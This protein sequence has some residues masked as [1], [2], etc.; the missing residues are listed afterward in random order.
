M[1]QRTS[2]TARPAAAKRQSL[3]SR[4]FLALLVV[5]FTVAL[6]D[7]IFRWL[8]IPIG[9]DLVASDD[10]VRSVGSAV[11]LVPFILLAGLAGFAADRYSKRSVMM[12]AKLAEIVVMVLGIIA[13]LSG[14]VVFLAVVLF[15]MGA[16]STF[17][18]PAKYGSIPEIVGPKLVSVANGWIGMTT[19]MAVIL[20]TVIGN[21]IYS[22]TTLTGGPAGIGPGQH[23][24]WINAAV[25]IGIATVG[26]LASFAVG[27]LPAGNPQSKAPRN[28]FAQTGRDLKLLYSHRGLFLAALGSAYFWSL[29]VLATLNID[30]LAVPELVGSTGQQYVGPMLAI[31]TLGIGLGSL[32][33]GIWSRGRIELGM[34]GIGALGIAL[35]AIMFIAVPTGTGQWWSVPYFVTCF[36]LFA[37]GAT[38]GLYDIPLLAFLQERSP[39]ESRGRILA[40]YNFLSFSGMLAFSGLFGLL[41]EVMGLPARGIFLLAGLATLPIACFIIYLVPV[42]TFRFVFDQFVRTVYGM[43]IVGREN[44]PQEGGAVVVSNHIS[45]LDGMIIMLAMPRHIRMVAVS[46][47]VSWGVVGR[48][49]RRAGVIPI[50]LRRKAMAHAMREAKQAVRDGKLVGLF[51]EGGISRT[52]QLI[53]FRPGFLHLVDDETPVVPVFIDGL[54]GSIFSF[55]RRR[56][57]WK[58]PRRLR[59]PLTV[60]IGQPIYG[61][62]TLHQV[63]RAVGELSVTAAQNRRGRFLVPPRQFLRQARAN[64]FRTKAADSLGMSVTGAKLLLGSFVLRRVLRRNHLASPQK[65]Q[66][67]GVL[68]PPSVGGLVV[69]AALAI[70]RRGAVNLNYTVSNDVLNHCLRSCCIRHVL[71]SRRF[72]ERFEFDLDAELVFIE[73]LP[74]RAGWL[75]KLTALLGTYL[76]PAWV[77]ERVLKLTRIKPDDLLTVVFT[78]GSTGRPKGV[79]LSQMNVGSNVEAFEQ[80]LDIRRNDVLCGILPFFHSFGYS[81]TLWAALQLL[82]KVVYHFNP[83][84][85]RQVGNL[86]RQHRATILVA[87]PTFLRSYVR[88]CE[89]EDF[90]HL[91]VVI[92]GAEKLPPDV[93]QAFEERFGVRPWEGYGTTET[94]P[95]VSSNIPASR[96]RDPWFDDARPGSVGRPMPYVIAK[97]A[98]VDTGED[99]GYDK[100]GMLW[101]KGPNVMQ[102][103]LGDPE[104]TAEVI[105]DGWYKTGDIAQIDR[106]NF[107]HIT[108][109]QSRFSKIAG[110]MV[111][112]LRIEEA[113]SQLLQLGDQDETT[114]AV[115]GV[116]DPKKGERIVVLYSALPT[117]PEE[118]CRRLGSESGL[119]TIW[120]PSPRSFYRVNQIPVL[121]S[122]KLDLKRLHDLAV[123]VAAQA[124]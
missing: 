34:V 121:G 111:P 119:P 73:D 13:I 120:I 46:D 105:R 112:H 50:P 26:W 124:D 86:C 108:G 38:A 63:N 66:Y 114:L 107:I 81:T 49:A 2:A 88:R 16:Q 75:D 47:Y 41:G 123:Q 39:A 79:M 42:D 87:T 10:L 59:Y 78:S 27:R 55:E 106:D 70:D 94:S 36:W 89:P 48:L 65:E 91:D 72:L 14:N 77:T 4:S 80:V 100:S 40:A 57:F 53:G 104:Q 98:D 116:P 101:V 102:G 122:G 35:T 29:G 67:V 71:T 17:F 19:M 25:L 113:I 6:N 12:G 28:P 115:T 51:P 44:I 56:F 68:L 30:K 109:R 32:L 99:L 85:P 15:L 21:W 103:Y 11:F 62:K 9:K 23:R 18:S 118:I 93:A 45:W 1:L 58:W 8:L 5:Q 117:Q 37:L 64:L 33:A 69:N 43:R 74:A 20:G 84:E 83:L 54:W 96:I 24:W 76:L 90:A 31:L 82:P 97:V 92:T 95:V 60:Y 61:P 52:G 3:W 7:N 110:E 22:L